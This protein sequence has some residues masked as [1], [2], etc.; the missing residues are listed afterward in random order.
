MAFA[1]IPLLCIMQMDAGDEFVVA[2]CMNL[3]LWLHLM[4]L[5]ANTK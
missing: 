4:Q 3:W 1:R 2:V 5:F